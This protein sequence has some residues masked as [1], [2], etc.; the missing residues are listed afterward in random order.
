MQRTR[1]SPPIRQIGGL[2]V[3]R[4]YVL[5]RLRNVARLPIRPWVSLQPWDV[6]VRLA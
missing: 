3:G 4:V 6:G 5:R 2:V 1:K